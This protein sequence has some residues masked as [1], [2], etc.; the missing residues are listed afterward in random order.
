VAKG[1]GWLAERIREIARAH[2]VPIVEN[3]PLAQALY[4][5]AEVG[6]VIPGELFGAVARCWPTSSG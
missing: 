6:D 1:R 5:G 4:K 3:V 2:G